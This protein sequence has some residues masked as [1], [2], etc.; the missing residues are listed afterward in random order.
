MVQCYLSDLEASCP[1]PRCR[2]VGFRRVYLRPGESC[3]VSFQI[4]PEMMALIDEAGEARLEEGRFRLT[5]GGC[6]PGERGRALGAPEPLSAEITQAPNPDT[7]GN[8]RFSSI[9]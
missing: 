5:V 3:P 9:G 1:V 7:S 2:L 4:T 8:T 6:S